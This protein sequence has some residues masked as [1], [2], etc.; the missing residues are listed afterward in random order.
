M[1]ISGLTTDKQ[2]GNWLII[3]IGLLI[4]P[5]VRLAMEE[6]ARGFGTSADL[7]SWFLA[8]VVIILGAYNLSINA[9]K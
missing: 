3:G 2:L 7:Y 6:F 4:L 9:K 8:I 1:K 5:F